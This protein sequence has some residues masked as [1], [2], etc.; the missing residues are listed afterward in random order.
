MI[1]LA[2]LIGFGW[3][4]SL[5]NKTTS[6]Y[7][8][9]NKSL[10]WVVAM[11]SIVA[12]ETSVL[13]FISIP[14]IA[15]RGNWFFLQ[16]AFGYILGRILVSIFFLPKYFSSGITSIYEILG[17]RFD[18]DIQKIASGVF[19]L[20]RILADGIRFLATAVIVQVV[21]GWSLPVAVLL[22]GVVTLIYS[23]LGGI[24]TI[25]W[26]DSFQFILYLLGGLISIIYILLHS[27][28]SALA[29]ISDLNGAEKTKIFNFSG[30]LFK[31]PYFF[32]SAV[33]GGMFLS[34]SSH[35][36]DHMMVQRV[37]GTKDLR[38]GQKAMIGSGIF[39]MLQFGIF[40]LAGS[41]IFH[42]FDGIPLQK[43]REFSSF[44]VDH[45][46]I[47][48]RGL[49]L[50]GIFS[51]AMSTLSSSI[52]SLASSTIVDWFGG[53]SS[54]KTSRIVSLFW[55]SVLISIALIFDESDS[56]IVIIGLQ[57]ASFTYGGLLGL[58][59]LTKINRKFNSIS[60]ITG[61]ISSFLIVFYLKQ[62]GLAWTWFIMISVVVNICVTIFIDLFIKNLYSRTFI[63]FIL[64]ITLALGTISFF[65]SSVE[66]D[67]S[68][69]S[70]I[71]T[72][73]LHK[74]DAKYHT[75]ITQPERYRAQI[76]YTQIDRD[77][78]NLPKFT[79]HTFGFNPNSYFYP[80]STIKLPIAALALEKLNTIEN[81][82]KDTHLNILPGPDKLT[83]V[84]ND[85]SSEDGYAT[86]GH[87]IHKLLIV[88]DNESY[89]RLYEFLGREH[90]NRRLWELGHIQT[91]I[92]HRLNLQ[93][94]INENRYTNGF[95]FYK[96]S[97]M[98]YEQPRQISELHLDIPFNDYLIG[99]SHYFKSKK[100]DRSMD[101]S[102]KNFM[103]LLDQHHFLIKLMFPEISNSKT[104]LN[105]TR[106]DYDFIRDKMS[107]LPR[108][109]ESPRYDESYYDSYCKFF[110]YGNSRKA[111]PNQVSI[112]NKSG[113]A[114]GFLLD[115]AY[116]VDI[117]NK[118]E[119]FLSAVVYGNSNGI[120]NDDSYD[121]DSLTIPFLAD[122][123]KA[124]Y[125][126][127]LER[128]KE[129]APDFTYLSKLES[130]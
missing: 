96:D 46:P 35:G 116:I 43:D 12:T 74:L 103:N 100:F 89:N 75:I 94:S 54:I 55:A 29:I 114:Y 76:I 16:L 53:R 8:L 23:A 105:L 27:D 64:T 73:L 66:H 38:S 60:L 125:E 25:V 79:E 18:K 72:D 120:L 118:I 49:L 1:F 51:A 14:G 22:I 24:R 32:I 87:Y 93:L 78:N 34:F 97:L 48:L 110:L 85:S 77:I 104:Q 57:I 130:L 4:Q 115:N 61:L 127:E 112:F 129:F 7:F 123:G 69:D 30:E 121:Y 91:R 31:D 40:L 67:K 20:T 28:N 106:S 82:D 13:T 36:V 71:L 3:Y 102:N 26:V 95:Q 37:L 41:L 21:T 108:E 33:I 56:A 58:F 17:E 65:K 2:G 68:I 122:L 99:D 9:G 19:L 45:L 92:K 39:V 52:N 88:S 117:E 63:F 59:L 44:I 5:Q 50:A 90:I 119:F 81:I 98:V 128:N 6:D 15:Y 80:A 70:K 101:F 84:I 109:S 83:G 86:I 111:I 42:F 107:A 47:G 10:P 62:V 124:V 11:F 113:L 126:Y